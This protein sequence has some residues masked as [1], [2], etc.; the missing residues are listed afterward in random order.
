[1]K[2][3][4]P[5]NDI[6]FALSARLSFTREGEGFGR[7]C[8]CMNER[9][10]G[11]E[12]ARKGKNKKNI[13]I[14]IYTHPNPTLQFTPFHSNYIT[15]PLSLFRIPKPTNPKPFPSISQSPA[16]SL[17]CF[18]LF[19]SLPPFSFPNP[20]PSPLQ[21]PSAHLPP[22]KTKTP[23][24]TFSHHV[25][26]PL[27]LSSFWGGGFWFWVFGFWLLGLGARKRGGRNRKGYPCLNGRKDS[28]WGEEGGGRVG[29]DGEGWG[30]CRWF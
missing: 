29:R 6:Y 10:G 22:P 13:Y 12:E 1:M 18:F 28:I 23:P 20:F 4:T 21:F 11:G 16:F 5:D 24:P 3:F 25:S 19:S 17:P 2:F 30:G 26:L 8:V 15:T 7:V 14:P 27:V 9:S